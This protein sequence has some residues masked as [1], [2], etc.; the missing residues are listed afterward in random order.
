MRKQ[1]VHKRRYRRLVLSTVTYALS[2]VLLLQGFAIVS[3][4]F[5]QDPKPGPPTSKGKRNPPVS[6]NTRDLIDLGTVNMEELARSKTYAPTLDAPV[7]IKP[8]HPPN[9]RPDEDRGG[10][11]I[12]KDTQVST[13]TRVIGPM[14]AIPTV[15]SPRVT[16][17][18]KSDNLTLGSIPPDAPAPFLATSRRYPSQTAD[19]RRKPARHRPLGFTITK[20]RHRP[21]FADSEPEGL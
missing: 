18:F 3:P 15:P 9:N 2:L 20:D 6:A 16:R 11:K 13:S 12:P 5:G 10:V 19:T 21:G 7:E 17:T 8:I 4:S 1:H 14:A